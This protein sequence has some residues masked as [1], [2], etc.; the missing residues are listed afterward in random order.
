MKKLTKK[1]SPIFIAFSAVVCAVVWRPGGTKAAPT[2]SD[3]EISFSGVLVDDGEPLSGDQDIS[4][5]FYGDAEGTAQLC[6]AI[7]ETVQADP[8][9]GF[10]VP[11]TQDCVQALKRERSSWFAVEVNSTMLPLTRVP[12][13]IYALRA[14][15]TNAG[16]RLSPMVRDGAD[17]SRFVGTGIWDS[18]FDTRCSF[19]T[20]D[21]QTGEVRCLPSG[22]Y[23]GTTGSTTTG[24]TTAGTTTSAGTVG[25]CTVDGVNCC[26]YGTITDDPNC[27]APSQQFKPVYYINEGDKFMIDHN[28]N[29][30]KVYQV[31]PASRPAYYRQQTNC[32]CPEVTS[33]LGERGAEIPLSEFVLISDEAPL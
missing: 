14:D 32:S 16:S 30:T 18:H 22:S 5:T 4:L 7:S 13:A 29:P 15:A 27:G 9:G 33:T 3:E 6:P 19:Q 25:G 10:S 28:E 1:A 17:G 31:E 2:A 23:G 21:N 12:T 20:V 24:T 8:A 26:A 11:L